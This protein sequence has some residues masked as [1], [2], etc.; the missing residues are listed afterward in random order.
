MTSVRRRGTTTEGRWTDSSR[1]DSARSQ[2]ETIR[3]FNSNR[4]SRTGQVGVV[5]GHV[6]RS[7]TGARRGSPA[8]LWSHMRLAFPLLV[9][10][11]LA[12][13]PAPRPQPR[14]DTAL[15][16]HARALLRSSPLI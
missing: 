16:D 10:C 15:L 3:V 13:T 2:N 6:E 7:S 11:L 1:P 12:M 5:A 4:S 8:I 9:I 14:T